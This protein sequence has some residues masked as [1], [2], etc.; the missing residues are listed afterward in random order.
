MVS[1]LRLA[2][3]SHCQESDDLFKIVINLIL[4]DVLEAI[5]YTVVSMLASQETSLLW[6]FGQR[7]YRQKKKIKKAVITHFLKT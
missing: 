4:T 1:T 2:C 5:Q 7:I 6:P 3:C